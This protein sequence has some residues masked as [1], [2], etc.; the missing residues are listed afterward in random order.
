[1]WDLREIQR[2]AT[3]KAQEKWIL[4]FMGYD[5]KI[6]YKRGIDYIG[7]WVYY[8]GFYILSYIYLVK[9]LYYIGFP[10]LNSWLDEWTN[11]PINIL[12]SFFLL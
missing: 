11:N 10:F 7:W 9:G 4:N 3:I 12:T 6:E 2:K 8:I 5:F 1:M